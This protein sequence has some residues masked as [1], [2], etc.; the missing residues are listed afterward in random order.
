MKNQL[1]DPLCTL[2]KLVQ[3]NFKENYTKISID[4]HVIVLHEPSN[5]Q[6]FIRFMHG[7]GRDNIGEIYYAIVRLVKWFMIDNN[8]NINNNDNTNTN[9]NV[10]TNTN[11]TVNTNDNVS[12]KNELNSKIDQFQC[13]EELNENSH[14]DNEDSQEYQ[15]QTNQ[16]NQDYDNAI[17][18]FSPQ[19]VELKS[20][21]A[22]SYDSGNFFDEMLKNKN[23]TNVSTNVTTNISTNMHFRKLV[24]YLING[25]EKLQSTYKNGLV[26]LAIQFYINILRCGLNNVFDNNLLPFVIEEEDKNSY[27]F[28]DYNK[29]K[30]FWN[31]KDLE[32]ICGLYDEC[33]EIQHNKELNGSRKAAYIRGKLKNVDAILNINEQK[34]QSLINN[35]KRG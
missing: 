6:P 13:D 3:L 14:Q 25:L 18:S 21:S 19:V 31:I 33:F 12:T 11:I 29:I 17:K 4:N 24:G 22:K 26:V 9:P 23:K 32:Y 28:L 34:F 8:E 16:D 30:N 35:N 5:I 15:E 10:T 1:L 27:N 20:T 7:D 2:V